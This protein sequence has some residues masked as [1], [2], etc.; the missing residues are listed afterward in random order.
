MLSTLTRKFDTNCNIS[1]VESSKLTQVKVW[2]VLFKLTTFYLK[3]QTQSFVK[4]YAQ[5]LKCIVFL[6]RSNS[7]YLLSEQLVKTRLI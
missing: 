6:N 7:F 1:R 2:Q 4:I 3:T 5:N